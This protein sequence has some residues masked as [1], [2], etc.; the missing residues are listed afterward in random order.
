[1]LNLV[2]KLKDCPLGIK[3]YHICYGDVY[4][5]QVDTYRNAI[6]V[7]P[8][9]KECW[10]RV[11]IDGR[12]ISEYS[13]ECVLFPSKDNRD[14]ATFDVDKIELPFEPKIGDVVADCCDNIFIYQG[15]Y[16]EYSDNSNFVVFITS[17]NDFFATESNNPFQISKAVRYATAN[18]EELLFDIMNKKGY[19]YNELNNCISKKE[20]TKRKFKV[21]DKIV[22]KD[23]PTKSWYVQG[24]D[25]YCNSDYYYIVT[26]GQVSSLHFK[27]QDEWELVPMHKFKVGDKI[28][29]SNTLYPILTITY[30]N[31][32]IYTV[33]SNM[34]DEEHDIGV[35]I[36]ENNYKIA[37]FSPSDLKPFDRLL[38]KRHNTWQI[39]HFGYFKNGVVFTEMGQPCNIDVVPYNDETKHLLGTCDDYDGFYKWWNI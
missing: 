39:A 17:H 27:D 12:H 4:L 8:F 2:E 23:D 19:V 5:K 6:Y 9:E 32:M 35:K 29:R 3:L 38:V 16:S 24:I 26:E 1:M 31:D 22:K 34:S 11:N 28:I 36:I 37:T 15:K 20:E 21:G 30:V 33:K 18:E 10:L 13:G 14:W 25:T 7:S